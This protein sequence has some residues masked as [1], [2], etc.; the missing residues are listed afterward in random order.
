MAVCQDDSITFFT[1]LRGFHVYRTT[2][3]PYVK[4][5]IE[6]KKER[7]NKFDNYAVAGYTKLPG[8]LALCVV[9]HIPREISRYIWYA[10]SHEAKVTARVES[11]V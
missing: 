1:G 2:W 4:Q 9:G 7:N 11:M 3:K 8:H 6:F 10:I 5:R